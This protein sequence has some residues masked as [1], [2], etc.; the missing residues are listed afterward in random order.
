MSMEPY[1]DGSIIAKLAFRLR[2]KHTICM[3]REPYKDGSI[4]AKLAF[5]LR[6]KHT[7]C[8]SMEPY[9]DG[10]IIAKLAF[11]LRKNTQYLC[12]W[13]LIKMVSSLQNLHLG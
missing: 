8:M 6:K 11:R 5:R 12:P 2:K 1:K 13:N 3:S 10:H 7:I 9:K 4:I